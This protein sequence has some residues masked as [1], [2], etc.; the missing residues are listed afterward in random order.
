MKIRRGK[1]IIKNTLRW[2]DVLG[3]KDLIKCYV[4]L[5][6]HHLGS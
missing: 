6:V 5:T 4:Y 2:K 1:E 3:R